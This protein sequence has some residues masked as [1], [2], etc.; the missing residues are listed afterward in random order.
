MLQLVGLYLAGSWIALEFT[1]FIA[2]RYDISPN[3][4]DLI[5]LGV[6]AMLPSV[7]VLAYT[8]GKPGKD[9]WTLA[10][11]IVIPV[12]IVVTVGLMF[13]FFSGKELGATTVVVSAEDETG[14]PVERV[15]AKAKFRKR[16]ALFTFSNQAG[17]PDY[18]WLGNWLAYGLY[19]DLIQDPFFD[20]R[21][22][23][24]MSESLTEAG[25]D[26][27]RIP[28][29]LMRDLARRLHLEYFLAGEVLAVKPFS[30]QTKLYQTRGGR[31][32]S[33]HSYSGPE[34]NALIDEIALDIKRGL[35]LS[36]GHIE[37][38][39]DLP[40]AAI[41][42]ESMAALAEFTR[43]LNQLHFHT[44]WTAAAALLE[45]SCAADPTFTQAQFYLYQANLLLGEQAEAAIAAAMQ[46][47]Y[48]VPERLQGAIKE[49]YYLW[50]GEPEK[51]LAALTLDVT[52]FPG[53]IIAHRRLAGFYYRMGLYH[54]SLDQYL[55]IHGLNPDDDLTMQ[56]IARVY[57]AMGRFDAAL[58][59]LRNYSKGNPRDTD[60][61]VEMGEVYQL[62]GRP[63]RAAK[64]YERAILLGHNRARVLTRQ[65]RLHFQA[66]D[67]DAALNTGR[68]AV[69][70]AQ[71]AEAK[72]E[73][74]K[75]L[76]EFNDA[77]GRITAAMAVA[78]EA[79]P[80][81]MEVTGPINSIILRLAHFEKYARTT[82]AD[83][84]HAA[85][86][87]YDLNLPDMWLPA[88]DVLET[89]YRAS[90]LDHT[91]AADQIASVD[92]FY[93]VYKYLVDLPRELLM[94]RIHAAN[95]DYLK[96]IQGYI[97][98]LSGYPRRLHVQ[99]EMARAYRLL[100]DS[101]GARTT[102]D[103]LLQIYPHDPLALFELY[104]IQSAT[105]DPAALEALKRLQTI[106]SGA[107]AIYLPARQVRAALAEAGVL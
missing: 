55:I 92:S 15:V 1:G 14:A 50:Q 86:N 56:D 19:L 29:A 11:K 79:R 53:D 105:A 36:P 44:D 91:I 101:Q 8:H 90:Q 74:L 96:A 6:A 54:E 72:L 107:D 33:E 5:L 103:Q 25:V 69:E 32:I 28:L 83:S 3:V 16:V 102:I 97:A 67:Y 58:E 84:V 93:S 2:D 47:L 100:G 65:A 63:G 7:F 81:E 45:R 99:R 10:D 42:S 24:Q 85:L 80:F 43:G 98:T 82:L 104:Q 31:L 40:I 73:A 51:A 70:L 9:R 89:A 13:A 95:G 35:E 75:A 37:G 106:W 20:N 87:E 77:L 17:D 27:D 49:V 88:V 76:E 64:V 34:V 18:D 59:N 12:N 66:G 61:L 30:I 48:K 41:S 57:A 23:Y 68:E 71:S 4:I 78:R 38:S 26:G 60:V 46:Y 62:V 94:A 39:D 21:Q 52:L 22:P